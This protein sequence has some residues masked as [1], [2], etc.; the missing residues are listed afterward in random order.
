MALDGTRKALKELGN[1]ASHR[2]PE[3][4]IIS[5]LRTESDRSVI[6]FLGT[7]IEDSLKREITKSLTGLEEQERD[8]FFDFNGVAGTFSSKIILAKP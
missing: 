5:N 6:V 7:I 1:T 2:I 8:A 3:D 4:E